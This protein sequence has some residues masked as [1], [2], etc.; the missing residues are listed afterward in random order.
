MTYDNQHEFWSA[1]QHILLV[2]MFESGQGIQDSWTEHDR[3]STS[4]SLTHLVTLSYHWFW[5][6]DGLWVW[7]LG[8]YLDSTLFNQFN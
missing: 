8:Y 1:L 2:K 5:V 4:P 3:Y 7:L 6:C